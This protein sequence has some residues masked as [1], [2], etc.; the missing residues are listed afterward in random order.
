MNMTPMEQD[1]FRQGQDAA[2]CGWDTGANR[3]RDE[4]QFDA[5]NSGYYEALG[6]TETV[7]N[8]RQQCETPMLFLPS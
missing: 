6:V 8:A 1:A 7:A 5:W 3:F 2:R 4:A